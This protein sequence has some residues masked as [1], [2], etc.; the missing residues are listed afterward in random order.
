[1]SS[2][3]IPFYIVFLFIACYMWEMRYFE[4]L[5]IFLITFVIFP[6]HAACNLPDPKITLLMKPG[7]ITYNTSLSKNEF[8]QKA[9]EGVSPETAVGLTVAQMGLTIRGKPRLKPNGRKSC[10]GL[11]EIIFEMGFDTIDVYIDRKYKPGSCEYKVVR[12]HENYHAQVSRQAMVF[13]RS[14]LDKALKKAVA[15]YR[16][17]Y[18]YSQSQAERIVNQQFENI[19]NEMRPVIDHIN[20]IIAQKNA[21]ID[22]PQA[23]QKTTSKCH[24]W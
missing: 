13:F 16:P 3:S 17:Q 20:K 23:Y 5:I 18:V 7:T 12:E 11:E 4:A 15:K 14:D 9:Q 2:F 10:V 24:N 6:S 8:M 22:T 19:V 21:A 1:M